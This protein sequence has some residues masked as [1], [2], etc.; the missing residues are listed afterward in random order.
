MFLGIAEA[1]ESI[2]ALVK[3]GLGP[4]GNGL[5]FTLDFAID[6]GIQIAA[7]AILFI[8]VIIF[9]WKPITKIL[10][11][12]R[13]AIDKELDDAKEAK[14][15]AI[16]VKDELDLELENARKQIKEMLDEAE[17]EANAK[18]QTII[19]DAKA[20][21][22]SR[23]ENLEHELELEKKNMEKDIKNQIVD[24]AFLAAEKIVAREIDQEKYLSLVDSIIQGGQD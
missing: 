20:E 10:E 15:N 13:D 5:N 19:N 22:K 3:G 6:F 8:V 23:L 24:I 18:R 1:L 21:A 16:K 4:L 12:R 11:K 9:F 2:T 17:K 14:E 7:T